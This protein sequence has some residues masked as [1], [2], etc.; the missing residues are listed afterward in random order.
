MT[1]LLITGASGLL[2]INLALMAV[3]RGYEVTGWTNRRTL[4]NA[5]F[6]SESV[7][8]LQYD[9]ISGKLDALKPD[10]IIN[11]AAI[12]NVERAAR[13]PKLAHS[14]NGVVPGILA[15]EAERINAKFIHISTDAV[16]DGICGDYAETDMPN[17]LNAYA[18]SKLEGELAVHKANPDAIIARVVFYGWSMSGQ[19]SLA[20]FFYNHLEVEQPVRGYTDMFFTPLYV[21]HLAEI[22]LRMAARDLKDTWHVFGAE[23]LSKYAF[24]VSLAQ[25]FGFDETL[26]SP[27]TTPDGEESVNR[28]LR[29]IMKTDK[30][31]E[32]LG[33]NLPTIGEGLT[34]LHEDL[35]NGLRE[36]IRTLGERS[37]A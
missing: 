16:F 14:L 13:D 10:L 28:S 30:L 15:A 1:K 22:L 31:T 6:A 7:D 34:A 37:E 19:R 4:P 27:V 5:P 18:Y 29:L 36:R 12:A 26:V 23:A 11:C 9:Q 8:L 35:R 24:G 3:E 33:E 2:G 20:E 21:G 32:A 17:P 25:E